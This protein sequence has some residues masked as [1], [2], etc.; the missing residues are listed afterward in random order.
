MTDGRDASW[1][2]RRFL[3]RL[4]RASA[5]AACA[6]A[7][8]LLAA[9]ATA[10]W[11]SHERVPGGIALAP[12][13][14]PPGEGALMDVPELPA[15]LYVHRHPDGRVTAVLTRCTHRGCTAAPRRRR[16]VCPC[17]GS[18]YELDGA[19]VQGPAERDLVRFPARVESDRIHVE[20][21]DAS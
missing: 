11:A 8:L 3:G 15:P 19:V 21:G 5:A 10:R 13:E 17:H 6:G 9:C 2:R 20:L 4:G 12:E 16:I 1:S 18:E 14:V 7:P